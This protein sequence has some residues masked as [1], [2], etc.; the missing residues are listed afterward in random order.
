M[1]WVLFS[2]VLFISADEICEKI[3]SVLLEVFVVRNVKK[4]LA[5][6]G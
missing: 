1:E 3:S 4:S 2:V 5:G 6:S